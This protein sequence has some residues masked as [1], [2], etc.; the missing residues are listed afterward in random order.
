MFHFVS[1]KWAST[2]STE[3]QSFYRNRYVI[4]AVN[5]AKK[6]KS[7]LIFRTVYNECNIRH[8]FPLSVASLDGY[9][10]LFQKQQEKFNNRSWR[11]ILAYLPRL[12]CQ[13]RPYLKLYKTRRIKKAKVIFKY[14]FCS[15]KFAYIFG[16]TLVL[17]IID[18][19]KFCFIDVYCN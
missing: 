19:W 17:I 10:S 12:L 5:I 4:I 16:C 2:I 7:I 8:A 14:F 3:N 1:G 18:R 11:V 6:T 13:C 15:H 9:A